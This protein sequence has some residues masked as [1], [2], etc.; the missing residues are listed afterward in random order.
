MLI[1][2]PSILTTDTRKQI[3]LEGTTDSTLT[4]CVQISALPRASCVTAGKLLNSSV[5]QCP[6]LQNGND[7]SE[8]CCQK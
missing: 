2:L 3:A 4:G 8:E 7:N 5:P 1:V 6:H